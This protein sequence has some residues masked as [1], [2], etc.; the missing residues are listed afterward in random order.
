M[1]TRSEVGEG[2][3]YL[4]VAGGIFYGIT[5]GLNPIATALVLAVVVLVIYHWATR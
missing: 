5:T 1:I 4:I 2:L 3:A